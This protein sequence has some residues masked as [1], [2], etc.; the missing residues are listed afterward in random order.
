MSMRRLLPRLALALLLVIV[1][2]LAAVHRD[3]IKPAVLD[4]WLG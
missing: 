2:A 1:A 3:E 4:A